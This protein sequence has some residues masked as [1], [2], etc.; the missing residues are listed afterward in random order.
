MTIFLEQP[1]VPSNA[2]FAGGVGSLGDIASAAWN[3]L[4]LVENS[5]GAFQSYNQAIDQRRSAIHS[6]TGAQLSN[7]LVDAEREWRELQTERPTSPLSASRFSGQQPETR[8]DI[9]NRHI[10]QFKHQLAELSEKFPDAHEAI[11]YDRDLWDDAAKIARE[12]DERLSTLMQSRGGLGKYGALLAGG[13]GGALSDPVTVM[14]LVAGGG[15][16]AARSVA[17]RILTVAGKEALI[18]SAAEAAIQPMVQNWRERAGL[19]HGFDEALR[20]VLF[21]G[22]IGGGFGGVF[23]AAGEVSKRLLRPADTERAA[24]SIASDARLSEQAR[25]ILANDGLRA[26]DS[27]AEIRTVLPPEA[28]GALDVA[29]T[30]RL[31]DEQRPAAASPTAHDAALARADQ[32]VRMPDAIEAWPGFQPDPA[33]IARIM[34]EIAGDA[35]PQPARVETPLIDFL[36]ARGGVKEFKGEL[37][38]IGASG[39]SERFRGRL[40]KDDGETLDYARE[41]AAQAGFFNAKYGDPDTA[42]ARS[43]IGDLLELVEEEVR[44]RTGGAVSSAEEA[45]LGSL[46]GI[47]S[48]IARMAGPNVDDTVISRATRLAVEDGYDPFEALERVFLNNDL[49]PAAKP[50]RTG[51]PL[52]GWS[53]EEL[54][55]ISEQRG[56][57]PEP[58]GIDSPGRLADYDFDVRELEALP[59][60]FMIPTDDGVISAAQL[61]DNLARRDNLVSVVEACRV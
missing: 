10:E 37:E 39:I 38:A 45:A 48:D 3:S 23:G 46:E 28:R 15:P 4:K 20:N 54:M 11:G 31:A 59:N 13:M 36:I 50:E 47:I 35:L 29:E 51:D 12:A 8:D 30:I 41:A 44:V 18:N 1:R 17:G 32:A 61:R 14:S 56:S 21:A 49:P 40:V 5:N 58:D 16:G 33:Q 60:D 2:T 55:A 22:A 34:Q 27:L 6:A 24:A 53:D 25:A 9:Y 26:A 43:T 57:F 19:D 52:P 42:S 7:P